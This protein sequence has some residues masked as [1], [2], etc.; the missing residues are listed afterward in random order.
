M[1]WIE[2]EPVHES[3]SN[4]PSFVECCGPTPASVFFFCVF[5]FLGWSSVWVEKAKRQDKTLRVFRGESCVHKVDEA[6]GG[7]GSVRLWNW[8]FLEAMAS[9]HKIVNHIIVQDS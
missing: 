8:K 7:V 4:I 6:G 2:A 1:V 9:K 5:F 3:I